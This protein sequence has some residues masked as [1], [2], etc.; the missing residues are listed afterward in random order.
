MPTT[1]FA[2]GLGENIHAPNER[3]SLSMFSKGREAWARLLW[4][5]GTSLGEKGAAQHDEL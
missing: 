4:E 2:W 5:L 1:V 3:L